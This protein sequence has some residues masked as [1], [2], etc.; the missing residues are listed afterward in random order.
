MGEGLLGR[1]CAL[2]QGW[3][4]RV[5]G[6]ESFSSPLVE[7]TADGGLQV[8][9]TLEEWEAF[10]TKFAKTKDRNERALRDYIQ[11][12]LLPIVVADLQVRRRCPGLFSKPSLRVR[13][14]DSIA[15][16]ALFRRRRNANASPRSPS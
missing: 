6:G 4:C 3:L 13:N 9:V 14:L 2:R 8:C 15:N 1:A 10:P 12:D 16:R 7:R 5:G 11:F